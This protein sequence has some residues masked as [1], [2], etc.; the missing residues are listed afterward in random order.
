MEAHAVGEE[1]VLIRYGEIALKGANRPLFERKLRENLKTAIAGIPGAHVR[2]NYGRV[3]I[4]GGAPGRALRAASRVF[5]V[6]SLSRAIRAELDVD[7]IATLAERLTS[8]SLEREFSGEEQVPF[9]VRTNRAEKRF[10]MRATELDRQVGGQLVSAH[11]R[12]KVDL[13]NPAL[14]IEIDL[15]SEGAWVFAGRTHGP[16]GLPVGSTGRTL[17]LLSGGIDSPV[18]AWMTMKRG[19]RVELV[20][21]LSD[22]YTGPQLRE[23]LIRL[24]EALARWQPV[25]NLHLVPFADYQ[26]AV[27]DTSPEPYRTLLY[28]RGMQRIANMIA[29]RRKCRAL[30]TGE[31]LGQVASQTLNNLRIIEEASRLPILRPLIGMDKVE[32]IERAR[33]IGTYD[34]SNLQ[35]PDCCTVFQPVSP[36]VHGQIGDAVAA[37]EG[38][39]IDT[40]LRDAIRNTER[41]RF[42]EE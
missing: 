2:Q 31:S 6:A 7:A 27:R 26:V 8:D 25:T 17:C 18:A 40:L 24:S 14:K 4:Q 9:A 5:G 36:I 35:S 19:A 39:A 11:P 12:L 37:E 42:P 22:P 41:L 20:S 13:S 29:T 23:K 38:L 33:M 10:P 15:R 1:A 32:T 28:R 34:L 3:V 21:F 30:I 16:G